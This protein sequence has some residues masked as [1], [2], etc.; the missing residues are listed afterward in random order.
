MRL[1]ALVVKPVDSGVEDDGPPSFITDQ[2]SQRTGCP[3][4]PRDSA[5]SASKKKRKKKKRDRPTTK[6]QLPQ[7]GNTAQLC[8][9]LRGAVGRASSGFPGPVT[10]DAAARGGC[11]A[12]PALTS[13]G[14]AGFGRPS[15]RRTA[16]RCQARVRH[17]LRLHALEYSTG[18][19]LH[20][21]RGTGRLKTSRWRQ[22]YSLFV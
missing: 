1:L 13:S 14:P 15:R 22:A 3:K 10:P 9:S 20:V 7:Q 17:L 12:H 19:C 8:L 5:A 6:R 21:F 16:I 2:E 18:S 4:Q 11:V